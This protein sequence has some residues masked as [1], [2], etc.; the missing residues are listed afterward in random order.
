MDC[1]RASNT[2]LLPVD[3]EHS[4]I[5]QVLEA[6]DGN[7]IKR[8]I[9]TASGGPFRTWDKKQM[10]DVK[11][12]EALN[13]PTWKMGPKI[14]IDSATMM[15]KGLELIEAFHLFP[16]N[17]D[18]LGVIVHP[19][20]IVH[21]F[22]EFKDGSTLAQLGPPDMRTPIAYSLSWPRRVST[23][24]RQLTVE[25]LASMTFEEPDEDRF[26]ALR[27]AKDV[28]N[29]GGASGTIFNAANE[30][31]VEAFLSGQIR[32]MSIPAIVEETL[33]AAPAKLEIGAISSLE[34][35]LTLDQSART[36]ARSLLQH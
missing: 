35:V 24:A 5:F 6:A 9:L 18:Q 11:V 26:P 7:D 16:V 15:N 36:L 12:E 25:D 14:T 23:P 29:E 28:L 13:H 10:A 1:M 4:A 30:V 34:D 8:I 32:F 17:A 2:T 33:S 31:A 21:C 27:I 19:Q 22:V 3:S 20:S